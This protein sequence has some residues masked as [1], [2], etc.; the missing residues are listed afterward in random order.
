MMMLLLLM[1]MMMME[2]EKEEEEDESA[3]Q[4]ACEG[5]RTIMSSAGLTSIIDEQKRSTIPPRP[6]F[7]PIMR[8]RTL[9]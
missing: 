6:S 8:L 1:M 4:P 3:G 7:L 5:T 2:K 9:P